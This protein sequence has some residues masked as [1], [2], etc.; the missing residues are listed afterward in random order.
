MPNPALNDNL[1]TIS[2]L[3]FIKTGSANTLYFEFCPFKHSICFSDGLKY[4]EIHK[5]IH[6]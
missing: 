5:E 6:A 2:T 3:P 4:T 1:P